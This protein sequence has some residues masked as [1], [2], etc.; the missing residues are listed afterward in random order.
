MDLQTL[1][2]NRQNPS[3]ACGSERTHASLR[4]TSFKPKVYQQSKGIWILTWGS[5]VAACSSAQ[6]AW[7]MIRELKLGGN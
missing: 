4:R 3:T 6:Q 2:S 7:R 5:N 1:L